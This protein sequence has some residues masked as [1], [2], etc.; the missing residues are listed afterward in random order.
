[1][2]FS[3]GYLTQID[4]HGRTTANGEGPLQDNLVVERKFIATKSEA[5]TFGS[6]L[7]GSPS[8][9][10]RIADAYLIVAT[11]EYVQVLGGIREDATLNTAFERPK[12]YFR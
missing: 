3:V 4:A 8:N 1:M 6:R 9:C 10:G 11:P 5:L 2:T 7:I 12:R